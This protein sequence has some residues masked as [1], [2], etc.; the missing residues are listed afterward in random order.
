MLRALLTTTT[1]FLLVGCSG[2]TFSRDGE[3]PDID[4]GAMSTGLD[5]EDLQKSLDE[6]YEDFAD[7]RFVKEASPSD[8]TSI[9]VL[10]IEN[11]TSERISGALSSLITSVE[12]K[13]VNTG[14]F[15][16]VANDQVAKDAIYKELAAGD[17][18]DPTSMAAAGKRLGVKYFIYGD[19]GDTAEKTSD[20][21]RVQYYLFLKVVEVETNVIVFQQ[22]IDRTKQISG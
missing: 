4:K 11:N 1:L 22:Q 10:H 19:V 13:L 2:P 15:S 21:R 5:R 20:R 17:A 3:N 8:R 9:S 6:W 12:T 16:V 18:V 14:V 7:S